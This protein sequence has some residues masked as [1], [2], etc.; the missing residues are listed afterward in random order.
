MKLGLNAYHGF[1][2][3]STKTRRE[4]YMPCGCACVIA[5]QWVGFAHRQSPI[6]LLLGLNWITEE[7]VKCII[8][9][10]HA[11][12]ITKKNFFFSNKSK[13]SF[14]IE[15]T[16][17]LTTWVNLLCTPY[18]SS[19]LKATALEPGQHFW[20]P[21]GSSGVWLLLPCRNSF[22]FSLSDAKCFLIMLV[23]PR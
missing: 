13:L 2:R 5:A 17:L 22:W 23:F 12:N 19:Y 21:T 1:T 18:D 20:N 3:N 4:R 15:R 10:L 16:R 7:A 8:W 9:K 6:Y 14:R 11:D